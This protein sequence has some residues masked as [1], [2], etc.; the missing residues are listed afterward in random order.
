MQISVA[1]F[2][3]EIFIDEASSIHISVAVVGHAI[4]K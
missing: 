1:V 3:H 2:G 4:F